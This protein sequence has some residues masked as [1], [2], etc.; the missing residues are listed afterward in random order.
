MCAARKVHHEDTSRLTVV[1]GRSLARTVRRTNVGHGAAVA[2]LLLHRLHGDVDTVAGIVDPGEAVTD[3]II[4]PGRLGGGRRVGALVTHHG[5]VLVIGVMLRMMVLHRRETVGRRPVRRQLVLAAAT[6]SPGLAFERHQLA[7]PVDRRGRLAAGLVRDLGGLVS[8]LG[9]RRPGLIRRRTLRVGPVGGHRRARRVHGVLLIVLVLVLVAVRVLEAAGP[10]GQI[11]V[12][13]RRLHADPGAGAR[14]VLRVL[15]LQRLTLAPE[16]ARSPPKTALLEHVLGGRVDGPVVALAGPA[17]AL[18]QLDEALVQAEI[19]AHRVLPAL[20]GPAEEREALLQKRVDLREGQPL[21]RARLDRHHDQRDVRVGRLLLA[22][23]ARLPR[24]HLAAR[25][26]A[27]ERLQAGLLRQ[28]G[29]AHRQHRRPR[30][31][32][33]RAR[34]HDDRLLLLVVQAAGL[35]GLVLHAQPRALVA[36]HRR[37]DHTLVHRALVPARQSPPSA[38]ILRA[39]MPRESRYRDLRARAALSAPSQQQD[40]RLHR[41]RKTKQPRYRGALREDQHRNR[42]DRGSHR[43][44]EQRPPSPEGGPPPASSKRDAEVA[45]I[46]TLGCKLFA[47]FRRG[48]G[49]L[50][51]LASSARN[52]LTSG[53]ESL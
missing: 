16:A 45:D 15:R 35:V 41:K 53:L 25:R 34:M 11:L 36:G 43:S 8:H 6:E 21:A 13:A 47:R 50:F 4:L 31:H 42:T 38:S 7:V 14:V 19:V 49:Q 48:R 17:Q 9:Y 29:R 23:R 32:R 10:G 51:R 22:P 24:L 1:R 5:L 33:R 2:T 39:N 28:T 46:Y 37:H 26:V 20:I 52:R 3:V 40:G 30:G 27:H 18:R 12:G 44:A